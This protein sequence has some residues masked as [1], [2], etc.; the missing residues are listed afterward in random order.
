MTTENPWLIGAPQALKSLQTRWE[1]AA[2]EQMLFAPTEAEL[3][4]LAQLGP[5]LRENAPGPTWMTSAADD[6][7]SYL[8]G[9]REIPN[10]SV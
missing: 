7:A 8:G 1:K 3:R 4:L 10:Q 2:M 5:W 9:S 6:I